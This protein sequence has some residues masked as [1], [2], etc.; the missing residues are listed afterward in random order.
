M[1]CR[2]N[3]TGSCKGCACAKANKTCVSCLPFKLGRCAN[4]SASVRQATTALP[5]GTPSTRSTTNDSPPM[6]NQLTSVTHHGSVGPNGTSMVTN[7]TTTDFVTS[8]SSTAGS[9]MSF[10]AT[11]AT[12]ITSSK[13]NV[14]C[15]IDKGTTSSALTVIE[16][17]TANST[18]TTTSIHTLPSFPPVNDPVFTWG[19]LRGIEFTN[20]LDATYKEVLHWRKNGFVVPF[21]KCGREFVSELSRLF[22]A[23]ATASSQECI[24]LKATIVMPI[25]LLQKPHRKS[26]AKDHSRLLENRLRL[27][28][29]GNLFDLISEGRAIQ[30]RLSVHHQSVKPNQNLQRKFANLM[31]AGKTKAALDLL[32]DSAGGGVL[33]ISD[34]SDPSRPDSPSVKDVLKT[35]HPMGQC[36]HEDCLFQEDPPPAHPA[37]FESLDASLIRSTALKITGAAGPSGIDA[38][39][40]RRMCT[41]FQGA[42]KDL[43]NSLALTARRMCTS[44]IDPAIV[45]PI[46]ACRLI[47]LDKNPGVRPI[48]IGDTARR[49]IAKAILSITKPDVQVATGCLQLCGG[50]I[51]GIE[52]AVHA[53][54]TAFEKDD[55][56]AVLL[57][58]ATNAFNTINRQVALQNIRRLCPPLTPILINT[59]R[60]PTELYVDGE[61]L[62]SQEGTTQGDPLAMSMYALATIPLIKRVSRNVTQVWYADDASGVGSVNH[63]RE[64]WDKISSI[65]PN[66]GY[67]ANA[68][69]SWLVTKEDHFSKATA[70]FADT[71]V[72]ITKD[73]RPYLGAAIGSQ[74][75]ITSY[76][77]SK[78]QGWASSLNH[79]ASIASTQPHAAFAALTHGLSS[80][81]TYLCRT[82][83]GI[84]RQLR[85]V[86]QSLQSELIPALTGRPPPSELDRKLFALPAR[87]GGLG[88]GIPSK[89]SDREFL[90]S[91]TI[92]KPLID[93]ILKQN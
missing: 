33:H 82:M 77:E 89:N 46:L 93:Q 78:A 90:A 52:A 58:D 87:L 47:A 63:L 73:G 74:E 24:A 68:S 83:P 51:S 12:S 39:G 14:T 9:T 15:S 20:A 5:R 66:F 48:G 92:C 56:E 13:V 88:I 55:C 72:K 18:A 28:K 11:C 61:V 8:T 29:E 65:G 27:W 19:D 86:D 85:L 25:L 60:A 4:T 76:A 67:F 40:W 35:K 81:W 34:P 69:K 70:A 91:M 16:N 10:T 71:D 2:C 64:W 31:F 84:S 49:I 79:L 7:P 30:G 32:S 45:S 57:I 50:Q 38:H 17:A 53:V 37:I 21:G 23:F 36:I 43:C 41:S 80:K 42:S 44:Y 54:R 22:L 6:M 26:K 3:R 1:C 62:L 59:Y 75:Y